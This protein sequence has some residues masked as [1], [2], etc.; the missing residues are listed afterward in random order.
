MLETR[1]SNLFRAFMVHDK[2]L[3][4]YLK[5]FSDSVLGHIVYLK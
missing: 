2:N 4:I 5:K 1:D 3:I